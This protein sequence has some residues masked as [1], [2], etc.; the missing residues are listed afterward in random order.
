MTTAPLAAQPTASAAADDTPRALDARSLDQ[1]A[2]A[3]GAT[4][5]GISLG[6]LFATR[7]LPTTSWFA[8]LVLCYVCGMLV[9]AVL[10]YVGAGWLAAKDRLAAALIS[11]A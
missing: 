4:A 2:S 7:L 3:L 9:Y 1:V 6:W 10:S 8:L 5:A 11:S